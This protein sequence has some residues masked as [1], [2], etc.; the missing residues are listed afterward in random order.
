MAEKVET[1]LA[2]SRGDIE[3]VFATGALGLGVDIPDIRGVIHFLLP[4]SLE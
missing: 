1:L 3:V 4:E 2:F